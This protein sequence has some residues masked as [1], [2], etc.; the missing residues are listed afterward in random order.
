MT[1]SNRHGNKILARLPEQDFQ[2]I[3]GLMEKVSPEVG[4]VVAFPDKEPK[5]GSLPG[6]RRA[7]VNGRA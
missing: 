4:V 2:R 5:L 6:L 7:F 3:V 1:T